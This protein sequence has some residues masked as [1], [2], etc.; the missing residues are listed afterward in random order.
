MIKVTK[1]DKIHR[2][3][4]LDLKF[5]MSQMAS[6]WN[7]NLGEICSTCD[8]QRVTVYQKLTDKKSTRKHKISS[9]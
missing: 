9:V 8:E 6:T 5:H 3:S 4:M 2:L 1:K 7:D